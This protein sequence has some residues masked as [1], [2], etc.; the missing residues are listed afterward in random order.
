MT[1]AEIREY[2]RGKSVA[3]LFAGAA[4]LRAP[5][6]FT[7]GA[8]IPAEGA[9]VFNNPDTYNRVPLIMGTASEEGKLFLYLFGLA[10]KLP[11]PLYQLLGGKAFG[12]ISRR[13]S[14]DRL[15]YRLARHENQPVY[16]YSF[17]YGQYR[18]FGYNAWPTDSGP[19]RKMSWAQAFGACHALDLPFNFGLVGSF[20]MFAG[21][22][23]Y[24]F[25]QDNRPGQLALSDAMMNYNGQFARTGNPNTAGLPQWTAWPKYRVSPGPRFMSLDADDTQ[26]I[27]KMIR[28]VR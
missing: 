24:I 17:Q 23:E 27:L 7:D 21:V 15:A 6:I 4:G 9:E 2:L 11:N 13:A 22:G 19:N 8:V 1:A 14:L 18:R 28:E 25:R 5:Y 12:R 10:D 16:S 20:P 26:A 3:Q